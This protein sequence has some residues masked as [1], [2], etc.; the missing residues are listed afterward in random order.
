MSFASVTAC[1]FLSSLDMISFQ[2]LSP[3]I[4]KDP[5]FLQVSTDQIKQQQS[6]EDVA[7]APN[8]SII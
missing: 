6:K 4:I 2:F 7:K 1:V 5:I 3:P 8:Y